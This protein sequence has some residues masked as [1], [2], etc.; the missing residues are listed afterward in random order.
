MSGDNHQ[1]FISGP[2][3]SRRIFRFS[4]H[5]YK[6]IASAALLAILAFLSI[7]VRAQSSFHQIADWPQYGGSPENNHFSPLTQINRSNVHQLQMAW[8]FDTGE[9]GGLE[10]TP[11]V[12]NGILYAYSPS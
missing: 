9:T 7:R 5:T 8:S 3:D 6:R 12:V 2:V 11:I 1:P 4:S 10:T